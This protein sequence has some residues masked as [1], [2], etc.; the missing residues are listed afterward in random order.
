MKSPR[1]PS[2]PA[3]PVEK[4]PADAPRS[5]TPFKPRRGLLIV[6]SIVFALWCVVLL[7]MYLLRA[8]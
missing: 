7:F 1:K 5:Y 8:R 6:T 2:K 4:R 3:R